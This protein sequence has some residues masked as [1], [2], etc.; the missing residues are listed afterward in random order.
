MA[1]KNSSVT[2]NLALVPIDDTDKGKKTRANVLENLLSNSSDLLLYGPQGNLIEA[3]EA[4]KIT[5]PILAGKSSALVAGKYNS[6]NPF[7]GNAYRVTIDNQAY[8]I[9]LPTSD[10]VA[11]RNHQIATAFN[12][13]SYI[14][15]PNW[16]DDA[17]KK[18]MG[19]KRVY[20]NPTN[21]LDI[22]VEPIK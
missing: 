10:P 6:F 14:D 15:V 9:V 19:P 20:V 5:A 7:G 21:M 13:K 22:R 3:T 18:Y 16:Y 17:S 12:K 11:T 4:A 1:Y 8:S 2:K